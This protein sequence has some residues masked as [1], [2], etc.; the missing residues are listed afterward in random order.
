M[1]PIPRLR[2]LTVTA[3]LAT[4]SARE[5]GLSPFA[6]PLARLLRSTGHVP[7]ARALH[8]GGVKKTKHRRRRRAFTVQLER[9]GRCVWR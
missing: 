9:G 7:A 5:R 8:G 1:S 2:L 6:V 3:L 4:R